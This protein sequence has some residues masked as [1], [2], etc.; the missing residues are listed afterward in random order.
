MCGTISPPIP[1]SG[2]SHGSRLLGSQSQRNGIHAFVRCYRI[3]GPVP[4]N[5]IARCK[6]QQELLYDK[7]VILRKLPRNPAKRAVFVALEKRWH[8]ITSA[9]LM[10]PPTHFVMCGIL[11]QVRQNRDRLPYNPKPSLRRF[12]SVIFKGAFCFLPIKGNQDPNYLAQQV[13]NGLL[14]SLEED[15]SDF[16]GAALDT[17]RVWLLQRVMAVWE[18]I[19]PES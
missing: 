13:C 19:T 5:A 14:S 2:K 8:Q 11:P 3:I 17:S 4:D 7:K 18:S 1:R 10:R 12:E 6:A 16:T 9:S 15:F